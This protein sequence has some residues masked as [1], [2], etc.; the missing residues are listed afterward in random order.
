M[1][2]KSSGAVGLL[3]I[4]ENVRSWS[5]LHPLRW[6]PRGNPGAGSFGSSETAAWEEGPR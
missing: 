1:D 4:D 6:A 2:S 3:R 5:H